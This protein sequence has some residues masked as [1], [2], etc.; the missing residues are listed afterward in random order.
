MIAYQ[1]L[2][3]HGDEVLKSF[4]TGCDG[5]FK[6]MSYFLMNGL[7]K[8]PVVIWGILRGSSLILQACMDQGHEYYYGDNCYLGNK[9]D[10]FRITKNNLQTTELNDYPDDRLREFDITVKD[11]TRSGSHILICPPTQGF[12]I[13]FNIHEWTEQTIQTLRK[14]TDRPIIVREKPAEMAILDSA[15]YLTPDVHGTTL[16]KRSRKIKNRV[17][18][19]EDLKDCWAVVTHQSNV[20]GDAV[21]NGVPAFVSEHSAAFT[22][23]N[24]K[25]SNIEKPHYSD[26]VEKWFRHLSYNQFNLD[27]MKSGFAWE[28]LN[29]VR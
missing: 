15:G 3:T 9:R 12:R 27:E 22:L 2:T 11:W 16:L 28:I 13:F 5:E 4:M 7:P 29:G 14:H 23:G 19:S 18:L 25:L 8:E 1:Q 21:M 24:T 6:P 20:A 17:P 10:Y 26:D